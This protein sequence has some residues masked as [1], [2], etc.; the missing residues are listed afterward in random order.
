MDPIATTRCGQ[1][2]GREKEGVL[3][4]AGIPYAAPPVGPLRFRPAEPY[5]AW[6][7]ARDARRFGPAAPQL[8]RPGM[9]TENREVRWDEDCLTLNVSTPALDDARRPVLV[10]IHG[11]A[12]RSGQGGVPWYNGASFARRGDIVTVSLNYRLGALGFVELSEIGGR[13]YAGSG[14]N[15]ILDQITALEWVRDNVEAFGGDPERVT[16][17]GESA[18]GMSVGTLLGS[19][20]AAG[21]FRGAIPQSGAAHHTHSIDTALEIARLLLRELEVEKIEELLAL[22][23]LRILEAQ[24]RVELQV[25]AGGRLGGG[26]GALLGDMAFQPV[27][28]GRVLPEAPIDALRGG[29][30][31]D[32]PVMIGTNLHETTLWAQGKY[33]EQA[34]AVTA[35]RLFPDPERALAGR[36]PAGGERAR[37]HDR[38]NDRPHLP[39]PGRPPGRSTRGE[40]GHEPHVPVQLGVARV[41]RSASR[42]ARA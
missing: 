26:D 15:G 20:R 33:A 29:A 21:L 19:P 6:S 10:W 9:I 34:L 12:F 11:G 23:P 31:S 39:H 22:S 24:G 2:L 38:A 18:G 5:P 30:S 16:L 27:V 37:S 40:R 36:R 35:A 41:R 13:D 8:A 42:D 4:F 7:E 1:V 17:A 3:L 28:G 25:A 32:V 14:A